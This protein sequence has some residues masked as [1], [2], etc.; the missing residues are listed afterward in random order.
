[1][2]SPLRL[3]AIILCAALSAC[4]MQPLAPEKAV[5]YK[6]VGLLSAMGDSFGTSA[7]G[8]TV[9]GNKDSAERLD[10]GF[11]NRLTQ[12]FMQALSDRY[13]VID[14]SKYREAFLNEPKSWP[15]ETGP[16]SEN[17]PM[18]TEVVR[19]LMGAEGMDAYILV[20][21]GGAAVGGTNQGVG[22][23]GI[24][25]Q[26]SLFGNRGCWFYVAYIVSV[27]DGKDYSLAA[28]MRALP[29]DQSGPFTLG[30]RAAVGAPNLPV[31]CEVWKAPAR[32][33]LTIRTVFDMIM[34]QSIP[35]TLRHAALIN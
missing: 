30:R 12:K 14:L 33:G 24:V 34:D 4:A 32:N 3:V 6:R 25:D 20:T 35:E 1:M 9:F 31:P 23:I 22:G 2:M 13:S 27:V 15:G 26:E 7:V 29:L 11:D 19:R 28:D 21:P 10:F 18:V 16:F 17:H 8:I 5:Q